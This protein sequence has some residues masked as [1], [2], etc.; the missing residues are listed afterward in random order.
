MVGVVTGLK[1]YNTF[2]TYKP[3]CYNVKMC[4]SPK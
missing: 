1:K 3:T 4:L 2:Y